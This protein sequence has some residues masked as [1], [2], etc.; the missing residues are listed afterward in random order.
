MYEQAEME[1]NMLESIMVRPMRPDSSILDG[2][3]RLGKKPH[4][5]RGLILGEL[6]REYGKG[7]ET[8]RVRTFEEVRGNVFGMEPPGKREEDATMEDS[9]LVPMEIKKRLGLKDSRHAV[10]D[11]TGEAEEGEEWTEGQEGDR[12]KEREYGG[13]ERDDELEEESMG[14]KNRSWKPVWDPREAMMIVYGI[15]ANGE[16]L[17]EINA[18]GLKERSWKSAKDTKVARDLIKAGGDY[19]EGG[20]YLDGN[21]AGSGG[22]KAISK[23]AVAK[24]DPQHIE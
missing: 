13:G 3:S 10:I 17:E 11:L 19:I 4:L 14:M 7:L 16:V 9:P 8:A 20:W 24:G 12:G 15:K 2:N 22:W 23:E 18:L 21:E 6:N 1:D 5:E